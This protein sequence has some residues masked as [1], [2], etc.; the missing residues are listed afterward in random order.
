MAVDQ[1]PPFASQEA[2]NEWLAGQHMRGQW[3]PAGRTAPTFP[4]PFGIPFLWKGETIR[5]G[6]DAAA[7]LVPVG[8]D[9]AR[10]T[11]C[12]VHPGLPAAGLAT[13]PTLLMCVQL[14]MPGESALAHRHTATAL[15][16]VVEG[17]VEAYTV[18]DGEKCL[19][20]RGD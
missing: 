18:V 15:R 3:L 4:K 20:E 19:M 17:E 10:R 5:E 6:L 7:V 2:L 12:L 11:S 8:E 13:S 16:F 1:R 14:V 9:D